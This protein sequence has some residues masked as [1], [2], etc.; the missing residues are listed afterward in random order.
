MAKLLVAGK[1][2]V[3][4]G[5]LKDGEEAKAGGAKEKD[6][7]WPGGEWVGKK[8]RVVD[9]EIPRIFGAPAE[10][11]A[12]AGEKLQVKAESYVHTVVVKVEQ[13]ERLPQLVMTLPLK[14]LHLTKLEQLELRSKFS[15]VD[16]LLP[17]GR[18]TGEHIMLGWWISARDMIDVRGCYLVPPQVTVALCESSTDPSPEVVDCR[19]KSIEIFRRRLKSCGLLGVPIWADNGGAG[20]EHWTLMVLRRSQQG[21]QIRYYDSLQNIAPFNLSKAELVRKVVMELMETEQ[22]PEITRTNSRSRQGN[23]VDCGVF[24]LHFWEGE[25]R[26]FRGEGWSLEFPQTAGNIKDRKKRLIQLV[27]QVRK[28]MEKGAE[29]PGGKKAGKK[30]VYEVEAVDSAEIVACKMSDIALLELGD[31]AVKAAGQGSVPFYG[32]SRCRGSRGGCINW[33]CNPVKYAAH[34]EKFPEKYKDEEKE[35][36]DWKGVTDKELIGGGLQ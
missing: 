36:K 25:V 33:F 12:Q 21:L 15:E 7:E 14:K 30:E 28:L 19:R 11:I 32:C 5:V 4:P 23:G 18:L 8:V 16:G 3:S 13:V 1:K 26:I 31:L 2:A 27:S 6:E 20:S 24:C 34:R 10:V 22:V 35:L 9:E 17:G 29:A